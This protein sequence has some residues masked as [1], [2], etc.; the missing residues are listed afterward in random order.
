MGG[1]AAGGC[2]GLRPWLEVWVDNNGWQGSRQTIGRACEILDMMQ[3]NGFP[4]LQFDGKRGEGI[5]F[6]EAHQDWHT[7]LITDAEYAQILEEMK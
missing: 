5:P 6:F 3:S 1:F 7:H 4:I 2:V